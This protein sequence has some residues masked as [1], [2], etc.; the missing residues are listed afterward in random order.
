MKI[1]E[2][3]E[4]TV[5]HFRTFEDLEVYRLAR[6]FRKAMYRIARRLPEEEKYALANQVRRAA[7]SLTNNIA[8]GHGQFH[9][10]EQIK[11][12]LQSRG[13]LEELGDDLNV[14]EDEQYLELAEISQ[15]KQQGWRLYKVLNVYLRYLRQRKAGA[16]PRL[17][18]SSPAYGFNDEELDAILDQ[19]SEGPI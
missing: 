5:K 3:S 4:N 15:L 16:S 10:L 11:F 13:L 17:N 2:P 1:E 19:R 7:V 6:E 8:E 12:G 9:F 18:E 14:C